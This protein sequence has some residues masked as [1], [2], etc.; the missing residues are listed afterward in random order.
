MAPAAKRIVLRLD[1]GSLIGDKGT[2][3]RSSDAAGCVLLEAQQALECNRLGLE[4]VERFKRIVDAAAPPEPLTNGVPLVAPKQSTPHTAEVPGKIRG[5]PPAGVRRCLCPPVGSARLL[6]VYIPLDE[7]SP[8]PPGRCVGGVRGA[9]RC[10]SRTSLQGLQPPS[11]RQRTSEAPP[12]ME[13]LGAAVGL[14]RRLSTRAGGAA[15]GMH[16]WRALGCQGSGAHSWL[17]QMQDSR[18]MC[19]RA[20]LCPTL[21]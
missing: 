20:P 12:F 6:G 19:T 11:K 10:A 16:A 21:P 14:A 9:E 7:G 8:Q 18:M 2:L 15:C 5:R 1:N 3:L 13:S 4:H 17:P